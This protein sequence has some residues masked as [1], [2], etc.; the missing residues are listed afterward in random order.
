M[1][2]GH[3]EPKYEIDL[4]IFKF[5]FNKLWFHCKNLDAL[6][7]LYEYQSSLIYFWHQNDSFTLTSNN[8]IWTYPDNKLDKISICVLPEMSNYSNNELKICYGIC[9]DYIENYKII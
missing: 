6:T 7:K 4:E 9:S 8:Y 1:V 3:N 5:Y 2:F